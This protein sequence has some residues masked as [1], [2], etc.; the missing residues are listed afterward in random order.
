MSQSSLRNVTDKPAGG[1]G[2]GG[3]GGDG[4]SQLSGGMLR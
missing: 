2:G 3:G 1:G 4:W